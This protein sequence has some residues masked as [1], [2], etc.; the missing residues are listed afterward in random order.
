MA[1]TSDSLSRPRQI[2]DMLRPGQIWRSG[3]EIAIR[4][5]ISR[6]AVAKH[7]AGLRGQGHAIASAPRKGYLLLALH[8]PLDGPALR[9]RLE[10]ALVGQG[11]WRV[12]ASTTSTNNDAV[13]WA[14]E[15]A[16]PG[17]IVWAE[18]QTKG[19]GCKGSNWF[20]S[21]RGMMF[22]LILRPDFNDAQLHRLTMTAA[23]ALA[24][25]IADCLPLIPQLK[26]PNDVLI[27]GR[28]VGGVLVETGRQAGGGK[29]AVIGIGC[30]V[31]ALADE[32][33]PA[34]EAT[35]LFLESGLILE[36]DRLL[37]RVLFHL[38][39]GWYGGSRKMRIRK[40]ADR[41]GQK[42]N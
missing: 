15:G 5:G 42:R 29:W 3:E 20:S 16:R 37:G 1:E 17:S 35:S 7:V 13:I 11:D 2:L 31:N 27:R 8:Q 19:R 28:K 41:I 14:L 23:Q 34:L 4:L 12:M 10:T 38:D 21:P 6:A 25:A 9:A 18:N 36:R 40:Q 26:A 22:S 24:A 30:N 32:L 33:P 39:K